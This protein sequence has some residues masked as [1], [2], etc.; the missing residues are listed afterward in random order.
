MRCTMISYLEHSKNN[1]K[2]IQSIKKY[3]KDDVEEKTNARQ[4]QDDWWIAHVGCLIETGM[5]RR[6]V[7]IY[8]YINPNIDSIVVGWR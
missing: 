2:T 4:T 8:T 6:W 7:N 1:C 3:A 5:S